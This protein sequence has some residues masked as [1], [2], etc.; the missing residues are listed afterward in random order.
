MKRSSTTTADRR[1]PG[2]GRIPPPRRSGVIGV[3]LAALLVLTGCTAI[4]TQGPVGVISASDDE[5]GDVGLVFDP[6]GPAPGASPARILL[7]FITA[8]TGASDG[9][10]VARQYLTP[11]LQETWRPEERIVLFRSDPRVEEREGEG[12]Y[13]IQ[14]ETT[15]IVDARGVRTDT[16]VPATEA[17]SVRLVQVDGEWRI[18]DIPDGIM[19]A[20]S[21]AQDLLL[22]HNLSFY[23]SDYRYWVPDARWFVRRTGVTARVVAAMLAGPAPYLQGSVTSAFPEGV[24]LARDSV[25]ITSGTATVELSPQVLE[26]ATNLSL[27]QMNQQLQVNLLNLNDVTSV[28]M[29]TDQPIELGPPAP[30]LV[31]PEL[32]PDVGTVQVAV[33]GGELVA[34]RNGESAPIE[35]LPS[36]ASLEPRDPA[37]VVSGEAYAFVNVTR[38]ALYIAVPG[39]EARRIA[40]GDAF[41][42]PSFDTEN[43]VWTAR[44]ADGRGEVIAIPPGG[45]EEDAAVLTV[46]WLG[47]REVRELRIS[48]DGARALVVT[49]R[50][51]TPEVLVSGITRSPDGVPQTL[52]PPLSLPVDV[53]VDTAKWAGQSTI[54]ASALGATTRAEPVVLHLNGERESMATLDGVLGISAGTDAEDMFYAQVDSTLYRRIGNSWV[55]EQID[56]IDPA[57]PG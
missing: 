24:T 48:R 33:A 2:D 38:K 40:V 15:G 34:V 49:E 41:T 23:S 10:S 5:S 45:S 21:S 4:P 42:Q 6:Q 11:E 36:V 46:S 37:T 14:L 22:S 55:D 25:P 44:N 53:D 9:Y 20:Q 35:D 19:L 32:S 39:S 27:Q 50:G 1:G 29:T 57:F 12:V 8:G 7:D 54:V 43:W 13:R 3:L 52:T 17:M 30:D 18:D 56:V 31:V 26:N 51:D 16:V 28:E 47:E